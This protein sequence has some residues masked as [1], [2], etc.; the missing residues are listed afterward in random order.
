MGKIPGARAELD[1]L[2]GVMRSELFDLVGR[3]TPE[4]APAVE[5]VRLEYPGVADWHEPLRFDHRATIRGA[6]P[7]DVSPEEMARR[8]VEAFA[9]A[10]WTV[11][12]EVADAI[13]VTG[14]SEDITIKVRVSVVSPVVLYMAGT[15]AMA[16]DTPQPRVRPEPLKSAG[17][18]SPGYALCYEC[19]GL[20]L[21]PACYGRGWVPDE[22]RG[23]RHCPECQIVPVCPICRGAGELYVATLQYFEKGYYPDH[24][25]PEGDA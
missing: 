8:A 3:L 14:R 18:L 11:E 17:N 25:P 4:A 19:D 9:A 10:G 24:F 5:A 23:R 16:L 1:R 6:R 13:L 12:E 21:C 7:Q 22:E 2:G 15:P 20:G